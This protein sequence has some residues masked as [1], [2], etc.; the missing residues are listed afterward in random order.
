MLLVDLVRLRL[1]EELFL[2]NEC[3]EDGR[4]DKLFPWLDNLLVVQ[5]KRLFEL[6]QLPKLCPL[7]Y[8]AEKSGS[9]GSKLPNT[10]ASWKKSISLFSFLIDI[11]SLF[12]SS[13]PIDD[14]DNVEWIVSSSSPMRNMFLFINVLLMILVIS[15]RTH[16]FLLHKQLLSH[17]KKRNSHC[18]ELQTQHRRDL[19][20]MMHFFLRQ[21][22]I[23]FI[24]L[25]SK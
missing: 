9:S 20:I 21:K 5:L 17:A 12:E 2:P 3:L 18:L 19:L 10:D 11:A 24:F 7:E 14:D 16:S 8:G 25:P 15:F 13:R 4:D 1:L 22:C 23:Q 6:L